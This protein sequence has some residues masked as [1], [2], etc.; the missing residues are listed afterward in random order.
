MTT[1]AVLTRL[2]T[3]PDRLEACAQALAEVHSGLMA[4]ER[5]WV[6]TDIFIDE[7]GEGVLLL[8][9]W[10]RAE[11]CHTFETTAGHDAIMKRLADHL[12][13]APTSRVLKIVRERRRGQAD[14]VD[15]AISGS[16][17]D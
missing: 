17:G 15:I 11:A 7:E 10:Q 1:C 3:K 14:E 13:G 16:L 5:D 9:H 2:P 6:S 8:T 4:G 12:A